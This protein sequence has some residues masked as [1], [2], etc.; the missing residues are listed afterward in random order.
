MPVYLSDPKDFS[1]LWAEILNPKRWAICQNETNEFGEE[2]T[3]L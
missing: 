3:K 2:T 1:E